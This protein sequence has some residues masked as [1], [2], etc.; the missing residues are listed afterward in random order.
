MSDIEKL[1]VEKAD[2][3][4]P[5]SNVIPE[6]VEII[7]DLLKKGYAYASN[8]GS[9]YFKISE[10]KDYGKFAHLDMENMIS[11]VRI[12]NDE[13]EKE[14]AGDFALWKG[15]SEEDGENYWEETFVVD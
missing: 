5:I 8:D 13:Y 15:Y 11:S 10:Y 3:V 1:G 12:D 6:M 4:E 7:N 14:T 9:I 2:V